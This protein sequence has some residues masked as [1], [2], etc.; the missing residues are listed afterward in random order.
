MIS[1]VLNN[2]VIHTNMPSCMTVLYFFRYHKHL[3][4]T[5][6]GCREG[7]CGACVVMVG[8]TTENGIQYQT[9]TSC[10]MPLSNATGKHIVTIEGINFPD[11]LTPVQKAIVEENGTQCGFCT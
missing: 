7:D 3:K 11:G 1:F 10:L 2:E 9:M 5:K 6:I 8:K 4:G